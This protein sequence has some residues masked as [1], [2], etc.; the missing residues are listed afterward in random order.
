MVLTVSVF[1]L[2]LLGTAALTLGASLSALNDWWPFELPVHFRPQLAGLS[3]LTAATM[4]IDARWPE[5]GLSLVLLYLNVV[6]LRAYL[7][8]PPA[9]QEGQGRKIRVLTFNLWRHLTHPGRF[10]ALLAAESPDIIVL[11][12]LPHARERLVEGLE[13]QYPHGVDDSLGHGADVLIL[14]R[15]P[16]KSVEVDRSVALAW[17]VVA[18]DIWDEGDPGVFLRII[19]LHAAAP[20]GRGKRI[21]DAQLAV[22]ARFAREAG[23]KPVIMMGDLNLTPWAPAFSRLLR[24]ANLKDSARAR[25]LWATWLFRFPLF[26]LAIDHVLVSRAVTVH[27]SKVYGFVGSDHRPVSADLGLSR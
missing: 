17:P 4:A 6:P 7:R 14:S 2:A 20:F 16:V 12:E 10:R 1:D 21:R 27:G 13:A 15:W 8:L 5:A 25:G 22:V 11:T 9:P 18:A 23:E 19:A 3:A 24:E 26:G